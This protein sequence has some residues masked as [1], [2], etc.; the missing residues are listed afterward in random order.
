MSDDADPGVYVEERN[1]NPHPIAGVSTSTATFIGIAASGP[2]T[3][4][5]I[6][7]FTEYERAFGRPTGGGFLGYAVRGFFENGGAQCYVMRIEAT[8]EPAESLQGLESLDVSI[9]C[10]PDANSVSGMA[11]A[12]VAHCEKMRYRFAVLDAPQTPAPTDG[13]PDA[14]RSSYA[15]YYYPWILVAESAEHGQIAVPPGG[16]VAGIYARTDREQGAWHAPAGK[17][18]LDIAGLDQSVTEKQGEALNS[19]GV[20]TLRNF[21]GRGTLVWGARTTSQDP[22]WKYVNIRRYFI[23]LEHSIDNG[24]QWAVFE[25][26]GEQLW[27]AV[28]RSVSDFLFNEWKSGALQGSRQTD[29]FFVRCD[30]STMTQSDIDNGRL[31][32]EIGVAALRPAE[33]VIFR[34][35]Q[36]TA[37]AESCGR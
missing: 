15:A 26:N 33:F 28:R 12:L 7:S 1:P 16:A 32:M 24:T 8:A 36:W 17:P 34:I 20:N 31:I 11:A 22:D 35:G 37:D 30:R 3:P 23:Y 4:T 29:A 14:L 18:I 9:V 10:S 25:P 27:G 13:P 6:T 19:V 21:P 5:L 2:F